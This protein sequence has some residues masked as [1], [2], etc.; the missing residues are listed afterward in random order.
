ME[1]LHLIYPDGSRIP[2]AYGDKIR[3][4]IKDHPLTPPDKQLIAVKANNRLVSLNYRVKTNCRLEGVVRESLEGIK[5]Y[6]DSLSFLL[7]LAAKKVLPQRQLIISHSLGD[8][9]YFYCEDLD[10]LSREV[11]LLE[12]TMQDLVKQDLSINRVTVSYEEALGYFKDNHQKRSLELLAHQNHHQIAVYTCSDYWDIAHNPLV[13][14]TS[15]LDTFKLIP[16]GPGLLLRGPKLSHPRKIGPFQDH[17]MLFSIYQEHK[18][19]GHILGVNSVGAL[20]T[21]NKER[22]ISGF[23]R[24]AEALH[25]KKIASLADQI[26]ERGDSVK[27]V[28][29]AGP[30]SSGKTTFTKKLSIQLQVLGYKPALVSLDDYFVDREK[31]PLDEKGDYDFESLEAIDVESLNGDMLDLF[32]GKEVTLPRFDFVQGR[33]VPGDKLRMKEN[34]ILVM[35]G[36]HGLNPELTPKIAKTDKFLIYVSALTQL[37]LDDHNRIPTTDNRLIRRIVRDYNFRGYSALDTIQRWPS[38]RRGENRN[39][40]PYQESADGAFNSALDY[41][42]GVLKV[43]VEPLL[44]QI[45]PHHKEY[46]EALRLLSFLDNFASISE[47]TVPQYSILRE[48]IGNSGFKY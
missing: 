5:I 17:P 31:T 4:I 11:P 13:H 9:Y 32:A 22:K 47:I 43:Y 41:E 20:N 30:S 16:Y 18:E 34:S 36:I 19:W 15:L 1:R 46:P 12:K 45:K 27:V 10:D 25:D 2:L 23:I 35:E 48:F 21:L 6:K 42:L 38:V 39:I 7:G 3:D 28:L 40:F 29:I 37:N 24:L 33:S 8:G 44:R 14:Q 26:Q